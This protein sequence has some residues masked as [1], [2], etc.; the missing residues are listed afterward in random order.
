MPVCYIKI[1]STICDKDWKS[2]LSRNIA[3]G[4]VNYIIRLI[5]AGEK[6]IY[7]IGKLIVH[8]HE[9]LLTCII[10]SQIPVAVY[11]NYCGYIILHIS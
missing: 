1:Y 5:E 7:D 11:V 2:L 6:L 4:A 9:L 8:D 3:S 10:I